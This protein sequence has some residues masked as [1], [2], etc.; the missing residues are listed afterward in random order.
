M[1]PRINP[2]HAAIAACAVTLALALP[3]LRG[4]L[5]SGMALHMLVQLP[6][7][8]LA[9][10]CIGNAWMR[11]HPQ[12]MAARSLR[13]M[14]SCNSGGVTGLITASFV[15]LLWML[16]RFLDLA[17]LD[18]TVDL[19]KFVSV[20]LAGI[21][22]ALSWP[23]LPVI[24]KAVVHLEVIATLLRFGWGYLAAEERLCLAYLS[25]DQQLTGTLLLWLG[26]IYAIAVTW[27]P[28]FGRVPHIRAA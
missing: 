3:P 20:P 25:D 11:S 16:P 27:R 28:M 21:A 15:M 23:R 10:Y 1:W 22:V 8:A 19:I 4:W 7:L 14:Q 2:L 13:G 6:L 18:I 9:G 12:G 5:E 26:A 24:A 17:R